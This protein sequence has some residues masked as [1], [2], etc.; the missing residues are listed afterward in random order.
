MPEEQEL[1]KNLLSLNR[2]ELAKVM[3]E[4]SVKS[5]VRENY[6]NGDFYEYSLVLAEVS[7]GCNSGANDSE[8]TI[9]FIG[10]EHPS[11]SHV[12]WGDSYSQEEKCTFCNAIISCAAKTAGCPVCDSTV[13][14]T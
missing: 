9:T 6:Q 14:C 11:A 3:H 10:K 2:R 8:P 12:N 7:W 1:I 5:R 4:L 13:S